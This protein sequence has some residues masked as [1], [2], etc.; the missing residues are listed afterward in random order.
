MSP[1][2]AQDAASTAH[3]QRAPGGNARGRL[4]APAAQQGGTQEAGGGATLRRVL[5]RHR[6]VQHDWFRDSARALSH[7][8]HPMRGNHPF[9]SL[10]RPVENHILGSVLFGIL[11]DGFSTNLFFQHLSLVFS[12]PRE[13]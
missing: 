12:A 4:R 3:V 9:H 8:R 7:R 2:H 1:F 13:F 10:R 5:W 6:L 11:F